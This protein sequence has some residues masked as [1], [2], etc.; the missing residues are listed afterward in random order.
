MEHLETKAKRYL[1]RKKRA[2]AKIFGTADRPRL[3]VF[4]SNTHVYGQVIDDERGVTLVAATDLK[5]KKEK[6]TKTQVAQ[7]IG[8]DLAKKAVAKKIKLVTFDRNGFK[9]HGRIKALA[10]GA[11]KG[12][13]IF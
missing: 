13:L 2:R 3:S 5:T 9:Y 6:M 1:Q 4:K 8:E 12:G 7:M 11:R 10:E